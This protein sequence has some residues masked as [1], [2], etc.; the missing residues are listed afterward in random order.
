M[1]LSAAM[2][3]YLKTIYVLQAD[4]DGERVTTSQVA[5]TLEVTP[6]TVTSMLGKLEERGLVERE[7][8]Q[9]V[10][11]TDQGEQV[12]LEVLRHHRLLEAYLSEHLDFDWSEVHAEADALEHH[13]SEELERRIAETLGEPAVDP[14]GDPIPTADLEPLEEAAG[15]TLAQAG[16]GDEVVVERVHDHDPEELRYLDEHG[17]RPG[18]TIEVVEVTP[19]D[20]VTVRPATGGDTVAL[21]KAVARRVRVGEPDG[22]V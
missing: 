4:A 5:E 20:L 7:K 8:Y 17:I 1:M 22:T 14:H 3:D 10:R 21:P 12:A 19:F 2:E 16:D 15:P 13:I 9:G 18:V 6:P 11:L